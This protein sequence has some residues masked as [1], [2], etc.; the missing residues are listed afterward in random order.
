MSGLAIQVQKCLSLVLCSHRE[1]APGS[2]L[3]S[4]PESVGITMEGCHKAFLLELT[5]N[6]F[7]KLFP[8]AAIV[9]CEW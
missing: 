7:R 4:P 8:F 9:Q 3:E 5:S 2:G 1:S 6:I